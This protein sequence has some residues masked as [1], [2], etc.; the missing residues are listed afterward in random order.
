MPWRSNAAAQK[1]GGKPQNNPNPHFAPVVAAMVPKLAAA[2]ATTG[3]PMVVAL[4]L[5]LEQAASSTYAKNCQLMSDLPSRTVMSS[6]LGIDCQ[7]LA[8]LLAVQALLKGGAPQLIAIP[9]NAAALPAA[10]GS[11]GTPQAPSRTGGSR[12]WFNGVPWSRLPTVPK[13]WVQVC[14]LFMQI[15]SVGSVSPGFG[16][17]FLCLPFVLGGAKFSFRTFTSGSGNLFLRSGLRRFGLL[18]LLL[19]LHHMVASLRLITIMAFGPARPDSRN[20]QQCQDGENND[21]CDDDDDKRRH[22]VPT[23]PKKPLRKNI[24]NPP[25][26]QL[27]IAQYNSRRACPPN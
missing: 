11:V 1:L 6:I 18:S 24:P 8:V 27:L 2:D 9:T 3:P 12:P 26:M 15:L 7:H 14:G 22:G 19:R 17:L 23:S 10:A 13:T 4:A 5:S 16:R 25:L 20:C 21:N